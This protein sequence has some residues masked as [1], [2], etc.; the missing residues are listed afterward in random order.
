MN[1][2][3]PH[4]GRKHALF[5]MQGVSKKELSY[6]CDHYEARRVNAMGYIEIRKIKKR[7]LYGEKMNAKKGEDIPTRLTKAMAEKEA[8]AHQEKLPI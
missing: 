8:D 1:I 6:I 2:T 4:C 3:C 7:L 5:W